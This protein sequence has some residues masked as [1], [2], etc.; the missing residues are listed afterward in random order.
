MYKKEFKFFQKSLAI[1]YYTLIPQYFF[2]ITVNIFSMVIAA[3]LLFAFF[4]LK[5]VI[6]III[7]CQFSHNRVSKFDKKY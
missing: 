2:I 6:A 4:V 5:F 3:I 7:A 1:Y